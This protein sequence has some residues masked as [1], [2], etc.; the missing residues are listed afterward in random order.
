MALSLLLDS[1]CKKT[2]NWNHRE[3]LKT[4]P[5]E[6][7][8]LMRRWQNIASGEVVNAKRVSEEAHSVRSEVRALKL[9]N[10]LGIPRVVKLLEAFCIA[11]G[12]S[13]LVVE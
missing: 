9:V 1:R 2:V 7:D 4:Q 13:V 12:N 8:F 3:P 11:P 6:H 10:S 5:S